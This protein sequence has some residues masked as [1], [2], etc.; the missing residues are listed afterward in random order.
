MCVR[1]Y[2]FVYAHIGYSHGK[3]STEGMKVAKISLSLVRGARLVNFSPR[4]TSLF[5]QEKGVYCPQL[6]TRTIVSPVRVIYA[7]VRESA[8]ERAR[9][10]DSRLWLLYNVLMISI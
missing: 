7:N 8:S 2:E 5:A 4:V 10:C 1:L 3:I 6:E 9:L